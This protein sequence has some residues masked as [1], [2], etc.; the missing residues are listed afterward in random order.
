M[1]PSY[2]LSSALATR[3]EDALSSSRDGCLV[4]P[5]RKMLEGCVSETVSEH[6]KSESSSGLKSGEKDTIDCVRASR[7]S[8]ASRRDGHR[9]PRG[10][11]PSASI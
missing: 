8:V 11:Q 6:L 1:Q 4:N 3:Q 10:S 9:C 7:R 2:S 5:L